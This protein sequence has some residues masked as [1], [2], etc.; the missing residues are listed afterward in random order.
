MDYKILA[1]GSKGNAVIL[2][3]EILID[4]GITYKHLKDHLD[5]KNICL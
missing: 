3:D 4:C 1:S 2:N 5:N